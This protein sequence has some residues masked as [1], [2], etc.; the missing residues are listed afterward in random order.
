MIADLDAALAA[1]GTDIVFRQTRK[2]PTPDEDT[3]IKGH[4][5]D[6][7]AVESGNGVAAVRSVVIISPTGLPAI[8]KR[9]DQILIDGKVRTVQLPRVKRVEGQVV[10]IELDCEGVP[11]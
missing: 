11:G 5:R 2:A 10:R 3:P 6:T 8:P 9:L 4:V 1:D 7:G